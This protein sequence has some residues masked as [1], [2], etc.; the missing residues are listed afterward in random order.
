MSKRDREYYLARIAAEHEAAERTRN[1]AV[2]RGRLQLIEQ[3]E[4]R[5]SSPAPERAPGK[6]DQ[7]P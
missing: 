5:P 6:G 2:S 3:C 4:H 1:D 7:A